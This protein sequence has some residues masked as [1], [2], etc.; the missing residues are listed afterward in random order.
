MIT[1]IIRCVMAMLPVILAACNFFSTTPTTFDIALGDLDGDGDL[2]AF[3]A[4]GQSEGL[5]PN[6]VW[7]NQG[8]GVFLDSGQ[9]LG[10]A[11][12][13]S[14]ALDD[15]DGDGDLDAL[16]GGWGL[17]YFNNGYGRFTTGDRAISMAGGSYTRYPALGDLDLDGDL[18][19]ILA[20]CCGA[21]SG[22]EE[23]TWVALPATTV[24]RNDGSGHFAESQTISDQGCE[25]VALG[26]LDGDGDLDAFIA[27]W[28]SIEHSGTP[29]VQREMFDSSGQVYRGPYQEHTSS[30]NLVYLNDGT[31]EMLDSGQSLGDKASYSL[32]LGDLDGDGD[33]DAFVGNRD[34][35]EIWINQGGAQNGISGQFLVSFQGIATRPTMKIVLGDVDN[36]GDLDALLNVATRQNYEP[37]LWLNDGRGSY[38]QSRQ[39]LSIPELQVY[40]L[41]DIDND[42]DLDIFAGSFADSY[43]IWLNDGV[44]N[45]ER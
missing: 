28:A 7:I 18:D 12:T 37:E 4:N 11:D 45:Y 6:S 8:E 2:D 26:D 30:P 41:G 17:I 5:Q 19:L 36:D 3:F 24:M 22:D 40:T 13:R 39:K 10:M 31:G 15:L 32:A 1:R 27:C 16:E 38:T 14:I 29:F 9:A 44:G 42:G 25:A 33:L 21:F 34:D 23:N 43:G 20:G 35:D